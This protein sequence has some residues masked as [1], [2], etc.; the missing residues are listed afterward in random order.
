MADKNQAVPA[1]I[2]LLGFGEAAGA[3]LEGWPTVDRRKVRA[4][5]IKSERPETRSGMEARYTR[6]GVS[7]CVSVASALE[8]AD[9]VLSLVTADQAL[10]AASAAAPHL[11]PGALYIDGN[12]CAP[13]TKR[14]ASRRIKASGGRYVDMAI[15][16]P[17]H[18]N[19]H[20]T[21][22]LLSGC[23]ADVAHLA[24]ESLGMRPKLAGKE[25]G[26]AS[27]IKMLRSVII[28]GLEALVAECMLS[29][30]RAGVEEA[31][32]A[33]LQESDPGIAWKARVSYNLER[34]MVHGV[35]RAAEMREVAQTVAQLGLPNR[36]SHAIAEWQH[37]IGTLGLDGGEDRLEDRTDRILVS[38]GDVRP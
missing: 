36:L 1:T 28:K 37:E 4:F 23:D 32:L 2:A 11:R 6:L 27:V 20:L 26:Q 31:V 18:P 35:R 5:D 33:S 25:V 9:L 13:E 30:R 7:G 29:A 19:R 3:L 16:A 22:V 12:S 38:L 14:E 15:M 21:P 34:M 17:V 8:G 24:L 10:T